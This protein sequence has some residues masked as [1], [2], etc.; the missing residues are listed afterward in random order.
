MKPKINAFQKFVEDQLEG[1][2]ELVFRR[3][4]GGFGVYAGG[5]FFGII[6][7]ERLYFH[8]NDATRARY[9]SCGQTFFTAPGSKKALKKYYE[10]PLSILEWREKLGEWA[11]ESINTVGLHE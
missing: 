1:I 10:V 4:F 7:R 6:H 5:T 9:E 3:M 8:T 2:P 11:S